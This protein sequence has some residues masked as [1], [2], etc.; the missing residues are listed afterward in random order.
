MSF[1]D[2]PSRS[3]GVAGLRVVK[4]S[5]VT[6]NNT[7]QNSLRETPSHRASTASDVLPPLRRIRSSRAAL[8]LDKTAAYSAA[9][10][11]ADSETGRG[12]G[13]GLAGRSCGRGREMRR[14]GDACRENCRSS[15]SRDEAVGV[16]DELEDDE[17]LLVDERRRKSVASEGKCAGCALLGG[18]EGICERILREVDARGSPT[19]L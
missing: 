4:N 2:F 13:A 18:E 1:A 15:T 10:M 8:P 9:L 3:S 14:E 12:L 17:V 5:D 6:N 7:A 11:T 19:S 16:L